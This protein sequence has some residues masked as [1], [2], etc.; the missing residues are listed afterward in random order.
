MFSELHLAAFCIIFIFQISY[1][2]L[3][4][5]IASFS[6]CLLYVQCIFWHI[7]ACSVLEKI[8]LCSPCFII[9]QTIE[10]WLSNIV[11]ISNI[12]HVKIWYKNEDECCTVLHT[13]KHTC[14]PYQ[15]R[16]YRTDLVLMYLRTDNVLNSTALNIVYDF[17]TGLTNFKKRK[18]NKGFS[19]KFMTISKQNRPLARTRSSWT[20]N[21]NCM[22]T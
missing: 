5:L 1:R 6:F 14:Q 4:S 7:G 8:D 17:H 11:S 18:E 3:W 21:I 2:Y 12:T 15:F 20:P 13:L 10:M 16:W 9:V 22:P 19:V